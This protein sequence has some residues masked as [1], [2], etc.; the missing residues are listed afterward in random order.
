MKKLNVAFLGFGNLGQSVAR[1]LLEK[2]E[3]IEKTY[4]ASINVV[5][6]TT[7]TRGNLVD[8]WG[9]DIER[10]LNNIMQTGVFP[11]TQETMLQR[12]SLDVAETVEYDVLVEMTPLEFATG[13]MA[14][15]HVM[16]ALKRG[17]HVICANKGPLAWHYK[18][19]DELAK[20]NG[21]KILFESSVMDGTP[22][23]RIVR[24]NLPLCKVTEIKGILNSTTNY[25]LQGLEQG[26]TAKEVVAEGK[27]R[28]FIETNPNNDIDGNEAAAKTA[29]LVNVMMGADI[30]PNDIEITGIGGITKKEIDEAAEKGNVIKLICRAYEKDGEV[31][32]KVGPEEI[33]RFS[34]F[35]SVSGTSQ[36]ISIT[37]DLMGTMTIVEESPDMEQAAYGVV[38]DLITIV[39]DM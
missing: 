39:K 33:S 12:N 23:F 29:A 38:S 1:I 6:I 9:I 31:H 3:E 19:I 16:A 35:A 5:A 36:A 17:K 25:I 18:E 2:K 8:A 27:R 22:V 34:A 21:C 32:V 15:D 28:G 24:E 26:K 13:H 4:D 20:K 11:K 10:V 37:T 30:T 7:K 14:T